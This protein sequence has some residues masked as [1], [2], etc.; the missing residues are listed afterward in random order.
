MSFINKQDF[1][2]TL[3][4]K[5]TVLDCYSKLLNNYKDDNKNEIIF[6][7]NSEIIESTKATS[8]RLFPSYLTPLYKNIN[9]L[10]V[11]KCPQKK[12]NGYAVVINESKNI[13]ELL[14]NEYSKSFRSNIKR[15]T[16]RLE[17]CFNI[18]YKIIYGNILKSE[19]DFLMHTLKQ[20]LVARFNQRNETNDILENWDFYLETTFNLINSKKASIFIIYN[21]DKPI[22]ICV[23]HHFE[24]LFFVSIPSYDV[25]Y[26]KFALGNISIYKL[27]EW[28][29][30]NNYNLLDMAYGDLEYKRRWSNL[31]YSFNHHIIYSKGHTIS[32]I[33]ANIELFLIA[34]KN[35]LKKYN[36]DVFAKKIKN[37]KRTKKK[38]SYNSNYNIEPISKFDETNCTLINIDNEKQQKPVLRKLIFDALYIHKEHFNTINVYKSNTK[39]KDEFYLIGKNVKLQ[40]TFI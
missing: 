27:L 40:I 13:E 28:A 20:M 11:K 35:V 24:N 14:K 10:V 22:H 29:L 8:I 1:Y 38:T 31:I 4:E 18:N 16:K 15:L 5:N 3:T 26:S 37:L 19:Y 6:E 9:K 36:I 32:A 30:N 33:K 12:I 39:D 34:S 17:T 7:S 23:N 2:N 21:E 25:D